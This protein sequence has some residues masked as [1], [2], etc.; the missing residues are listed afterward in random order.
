MFDESD[1]VCPVADGVFLVFGGFAEGF[2]IGNIVK[3]WVIAE[4][5]IPADFA[6]DNALSCA[7]DGLFR[8]VRKHKCDGADKACRAFAA[9]DAFQVFEQLFDVGGIAR[10]FAVF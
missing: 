6:C 10:V 3:D 8:A 5:A 7:G 9:R 1:G 2:A 4:A